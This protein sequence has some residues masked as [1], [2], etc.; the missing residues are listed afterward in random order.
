MDE[1]LRCISYYFYSLWKKGLERI[2]IMYIF[3]ITHERYPSSTIL[4]KPELRVSGGF[5]IISQKRYG[6]NS[7]DPLRRIKLRVVRWRSYLAPRPWLIVIDCCELRRKNTG[8]FNHRRW[9]Q[10]C[11]KDYK[12]IPQAPIGSVRQL[13]K[14]YC[15]N[16]NFVEQRRLC[17]CSSST[18]R[19]TNRQRWSY[20]KH[21][22]KF[23][24]SRTQNRQLLL[25]MRNRFRLSLRTRPGLYT[26]STYQ[27]F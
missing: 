5:I 10:I 12:K 6:E 14:Y 4:K 1:V 2:I 24:I 19:N 11:N 9:T 16:E 15:L 27:E 20:W 8:V 18:N 23:E 13:L 22:D 26:F 21:L 25:L 3:T 7:W 17:S